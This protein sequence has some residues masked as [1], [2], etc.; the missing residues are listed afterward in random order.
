MTRTRRKSRGN[1]KELHGLK[2]GQQAIR[3]N[4]K[5]AKKVKRQ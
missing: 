2:K 4:D 5:D 1:K 3:K